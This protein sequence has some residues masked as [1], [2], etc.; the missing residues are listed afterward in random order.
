MS[1]YGLNGLRKADEQLPTLLMGYSILYFFTPH[2]MRSK[3]YFR[4]AVHGCGA[5]PQSRTCVCVLVTRCAVQ[6]GSTMPICRW[7]V[8]GA[9]DVRGSKEPCIRWG[10]WSDE[11]ICSRDVA[12][13]QI[14]FVT[15]FYIP[16]I[17]N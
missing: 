2:R 15:C 5:L 9:A 6:N 17:L 12:F 3:T 16:T 1:T 7:G 11:S 13:C 8:V 10:Y 14:T 4:H